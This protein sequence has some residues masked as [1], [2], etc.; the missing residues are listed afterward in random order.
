M[1]VE[2]HA[3][4]HRIKSLIQNFAGPV[5]LSSRHSC[6][7]R[8]GGVILVESLGNGAPTQEDPSR[9]LPMGVL[10][11]RVWSHM[12][13]MR[14]P[15]PLFSSQNSKVDFWMAGVVPR[16]LSLFVDRLWAR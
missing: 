2:R 10:P 12:L 15:P 4:G 3:Y 1:G 5:M 7:G 6:H 16:Q 9:N 11:V 13:L 14:L 8:D